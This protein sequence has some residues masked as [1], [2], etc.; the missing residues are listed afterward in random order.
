MEVTLRVGILLSKLE[1]QLSERHTHVLKKLQGILI[2]YHCVRFGH[3]AFSF[4][5]SVD[6]R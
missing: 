5:R 6:I 2:W 4:S 3:T 1:T